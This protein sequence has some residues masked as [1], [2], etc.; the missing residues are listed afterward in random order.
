MRWLC[1][2]FIFILVQ[3][4][5]II[6]NIAIS[7]LFDVVMYEASSGLT[8]NWWLLL[9]NRYFWIVLI[10]QV[11]YGIIAAYVAI[12]NKNSDDRVQQAIEDEEIVLVTQISENVKR[13]DFD[14]ANKIIKILDKLQKRR[15]R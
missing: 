5:C 3:A 8:F 9:T 1:N 15:N 4:L 2:K 10:L 6:I 7:F 12:K 14:S 11:L 13:G